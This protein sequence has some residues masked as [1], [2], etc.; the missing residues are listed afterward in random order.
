MGEDSKI[1]WTTHTFNPWIGCTEVSP[2][3]DNCYARTLAERYG[4]TTWGK[5]QWRRRTAE[6]NWRKPLT[7]DR[8]A[9]ESGRRAQVF[10]ASLADVFDAEVPRGW[11]DDLWVLIRQTPHLDWQ[12][13]TKR[14]NLIRR[15]LPPDWGSGWPNVWLGASVESQEHTWRIDHLIKVPAV[16]RFLSCEPLLG[17][18]SLPSY[19]MNIDWIIAGGESGHG[20]RAMHPAWVRSLR[21]QCIAA[22]VPFL[23]KQW[24]EW[25][26]DESR[27]PAAWDRGEM[28][29]SDDGMDLR[30]YESL[31][32]RDVGAVLMR[33]I[34]KHRAGRLLD[35]RTWDEMP[36][37]FKRL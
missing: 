30:G 34:G 7:W 25:A 8:Q 4:W 3:C 18:L 22:G 36:T 23:F 14:P 12:L 35:G 33:K 21:D 32:W 9:R 13:L 1:E 28:P 29:L 31:A 15:S 5:G 20:A 19:L 11:R 24:G 2:G 37:P 6:A 17:S 27:D 26:P 10:C 16:V